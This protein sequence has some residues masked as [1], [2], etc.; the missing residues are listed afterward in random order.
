VHTPQGKVRAVSV[1]LPNGNPPYND[2]DDTS[3][4]DYKLRFMDALYRRAAFLIGQGDRTILGGDLNVLLTPKDVYDPELFKNNALYRE[5]V[6]QRLYAL[7]YLGFY[8]AFRM[9]HPDE[10]GYTYWDYAAKAFE[11]DLGLRIDYLFLSPQCA[12]VLQECFVDKTPRAGEKPSDHTP[13]TAV[14]DFAEAR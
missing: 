6:K 4:F 10:N 11:S 9:L 1:Y 3:K 14:F 13:L 8:D 12:D 2:P 5:P 7:S